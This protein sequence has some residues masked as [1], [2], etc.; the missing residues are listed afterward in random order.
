MSATL[1]KENFA[2]VVTDE[3][4]DI[5][6]FSKINGVWQ[7]A[8]LN[9]DFSIEQFGNS[10]RSNSAP[11]DTSKRYVLL[12]SAVGWEKNIPESSPGQGSDNDIE[13]FEWGCPF[14][15][16]PLLQGAT[17]TNRGVIWP[18][19]IENGTKIVWVQMLKTKAEERP[20]GRWEI[21]VADINLEMGTLSNIKYYQDSNKEP[22]FYEPYGQIP[23]TNL[24]IFASNTRATT[25]NSPREQQLFT[26]PISLEG[27]PTRI[28]PKINQSVGP[29]ADCFHEWAYF[30]PDDPYSLYTDIGQS[31]DGGDDLFRY[32]LREQ[33]DDGLLSQPTR[34]S[35]FGGEFARGKFN[36]VQGF[37]P[38]QYT[39]LSTMAWVEG[40]WY[41]TVSHNILSTT[42]NTWRIEI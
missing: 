4:N 33:N 6:G 21:C 5:L 3:D 10:L 23:N 14:K 9:G 26:L 38:P 8:V 28:S 30:A 24:L 2:P 41:A 40:A 18:K 34:I 27:A 42:V 32:D 29:P 1:I 25:K 37:P 22:A 31:T 7:P 16:I 15:Q 13:L 39:V 36:Q 12:T 17:K 19:F 11:S 35:Y 20:E